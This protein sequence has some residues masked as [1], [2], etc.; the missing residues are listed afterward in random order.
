MTHILEVLIMGPIQNNTILFG[1]ADSKTIAVVDPADEPTPIINCAKRLGRTIEAVL[2]THHHYDHIAGVDLLKAQ[3]PDIKVMASE[4]C[5]ELCT[6]GNATLSA[7]STGI[8]IFIQKPNVILKD[9]IPFH[10]A[11]V[12]VIPHIVPGHAEGQMIYYAETLN[13]IFSG[14]TLFAGGVGISHL[15]GGNHEALVSTLKKLLPKFNPDT[16]VIPGHDEET[17]VGVELRTNPYIQ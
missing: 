10:V 8:E 9:E 6:D 12:K 17:T 2:I 1:H 14:D 4:R 15:P 3:I 16:R 7:F 13:T 11:G 5:A